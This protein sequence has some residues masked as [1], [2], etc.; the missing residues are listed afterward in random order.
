MLNYAA[1]F[2]AAFAPGLFWLWYF[3]RK[4]KLEPEPKKL[5]IKTFFVGIALGIPATFLELL[6]T[7]S[8]LVT[9]LIAPV[10][11]EAL[12]YSGVRLAAYRRPEFD[13]PLD[14]IIYTAAVALGFASMENVFYLLAAYLSAHDTAKSLEVLSPFGVVISVFV[15]RALM[16]VPSHVLYSSMWG[17]ALGRAKFMDRASGRSLILKGFL[18][19]VLCHALFN[20]FA[21]R[22]PQAAVGE[23]LLVTILWVVVL[24][25]IAEGQRISPHRV[26]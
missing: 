14:G 13:E 11:E 23:L 17:Y 7:E 1:V 4:D 26:P 24:K 16:S 8:L 2:A 3:Y 10:I 18:A 22:L 19:A 21:S 20:F 9:I 15:L 25:R 12:K 5:I 6:F